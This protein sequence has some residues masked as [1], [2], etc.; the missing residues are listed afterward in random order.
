MC[1]ICYAQHQLIDLIVPP[2]DSKYRKTNRDQQN[3]RLPMVHSTPF[4]GMPSQ[5]RLPQRPI[6]SSA[7]LFEIVDIQE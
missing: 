3:G 6:L 4:S 7:S 5:C 1:E 2:V